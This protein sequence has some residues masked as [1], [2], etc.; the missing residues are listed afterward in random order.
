MKTKKT[1]LFGYIDYRKFLQDYYEEKKSA[2]P[3]FT[4]TYVCHRL[5][6][7]KSKSYFNNVISGRTDVTGTFI[8]RFITLLE[9]TNDEAMYFRALVNYNQ[10]TSAKEKEFFFDQLVR[11]NRT[12]HRIINDSEY[13]YYKEWYYSAV[14]SLLDVVDITDNCSQIVKRLV[15]SI[16]V[17]QAKDAIRVLKSLGLI[18]PNSEGYLKA[19]DKVLSTGS[20]MHDEIVRQ[21][22]MKCL[23]QAMNVIASGTSNA[24]RNITMSMSMSKECF[25]RVSGKVDQ[26]KSEIRSIV[27]KDTMKATQ[28][29]HINLNLFPMS[30]EE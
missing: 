30:K 28:V 27:Q 1:D 29:Y 25:E 23:E 4:H 6:Q 10:T 18:A 3:G 20:F 2:E 7:E 26:F 14:R 11:L 16:T 8:D 13:I 17:K 24:H 9:L 15:P 12:P 21:Y 22:Q 5:G 19:T